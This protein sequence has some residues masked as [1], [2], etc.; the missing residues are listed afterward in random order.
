M[1]KKVRS[2]SK[3]FVAG[4]KENNVLLSIN[5]YP[6]YKLNLQSA[7]DLIES[8]DSLFLEVVDR[9]KFNQSNEKK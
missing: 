4:L 3:A 6:T 7:S 1:I 9:K 5:G 8:S 2:K